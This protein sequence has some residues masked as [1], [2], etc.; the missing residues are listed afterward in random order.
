MPID[1]VYWIFWVFIGL[2]IGV[3]AR[4][5][6]HRS[7]FRILLLGAVL[8]MSGIVI[9]L[10]SGHKVAQLLMFD[11]EL[12]PVAGA[13]EYRLIAFGYAL[14]FAGILLGARLRHAGNREGVAGP[15]SRNAR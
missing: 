3:R 9:G 1:H 12:E 15:E 4:L 5:Q 6:S 8:V 11:R 7:V 14:L 2:L 10:A 13:L